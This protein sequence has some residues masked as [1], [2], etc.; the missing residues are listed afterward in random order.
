MLACWHVIASIITLGLNAVLCR[1]ICIATAAIHTCTVSTSSP[2]PLLP[3]L[4]SIT[5]YVYVLARC[6]YSVGIQLTP[7]VTIAVLASPM[8]QILTSQKT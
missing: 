7:Y 2:P 3:T 8:V 5:P 4:S 6:S 1:V